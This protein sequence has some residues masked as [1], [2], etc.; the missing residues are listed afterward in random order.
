M[1]IKFY[2][3]S[4]NGSLIIAIKMNTKYSFFLRQT[5][6]FILYWKKLSQIY[7]AFRTL[8]LYT[9]LGSYIKWLMSAKPQNFMHQL[10]FTDFRKL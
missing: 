1:H 2:I 9:I 10:V 3:P 4:F 5:C 8:L 6:Y 7:I